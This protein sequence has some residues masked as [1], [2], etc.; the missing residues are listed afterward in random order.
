MNS[1]LECSNLIV[2]KIVAQR[3]LEIEA[4][5]GFQPENNMEQLGYPIFKLLIEPTDFEPYYLKNK[6]LSKF[7]WNQKLRRKPDD[8]IFTGSRIQI[9]VRP[10]K[11]D[12]LKLR[13]VHLKNEVVYKHNILSLKIKDK[14][15][16]QECFPYLSLINSKLLGFYIYN[17]SSQWG[18]G[19][20]KR[21]ALRNVD[22]E[23]L[24]IKK[25]SNP[26]TLHLFTNKINAYIQAKEEGRNG[27]SILEELDEDVYKLYELTDYEKEIINE[28]YQIKVERASDK[29]KFVQESDIQAYF[30]AF[31]ESFKLILSSN[32]T[33]NASFSISSNIGA[34]IKISIIEKTSEK[35][36]E[37]DNTLQ[38]LQF[39][40][41]KQL[42]DTDKLLREEKIKLYEP[43]HFYL[44]KS[45]QFK[46]WTRRQAYKDAKEEIDLLFSNLPYTNG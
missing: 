31:K 38:V 27:F 21:A 34:I 46:D 12:K 44:I 23:T 1:D 4:R 13:G 40:K 41:N 35:E 36:L 32:H 28:F 18:K 29:L 33:L 10:L 43:T 5:T 42:S 2:K 17:V 3:D 37:Q 20:E 11:D 7:N 9:A 16:Y 25:I 19:A 6:E 24:P 45:N 26:K 15:V 8:D 14:N 30:E 22:L 39:V